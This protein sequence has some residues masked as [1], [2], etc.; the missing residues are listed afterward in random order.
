[1]ELTPNQMGAIAEAKVA[2]AATQLDVTVLRPLFEDKRYDLVFDL[3][4]RLVRVQ[5]KSAPRKGG[6][7]DLR[8]RTSRRT[9]TGYRRGTYSAA[10]VDA[11]AGFCPQLDRC[12]LVPIDHFP[13]SGALSLRLLPAKNNQLKGLHFAAEYELN[14]GAIAQLEERV[15]GRHEVVGSSPTSSTLEEPCVARLFS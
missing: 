1:M 11:V 14:P 9:A 10:D 3:G 6:V 2:A 8:A 13:P 4:G 5:C 15:S 12:Y 7:I